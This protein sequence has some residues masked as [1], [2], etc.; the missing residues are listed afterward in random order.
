MSS[1][2]LGKESSEAE[3]TNISKNG[4]WILVADE[5]FFLSYEDY[6]WFKSASV[7]DAL[8]VQ[9]LSPTHLYWPE[10]DLDISTAS[11]TEPD[12]FPLT[13]AT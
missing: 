8:N 1:S 2:T 4:I 6:P 7:E 10:L 9:L 11:I 3:V 5:E 12:R 13:A